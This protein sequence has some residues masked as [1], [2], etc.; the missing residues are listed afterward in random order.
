[1]TRTHAEPAEK[2]N[3]T[4]LDTRF[5]DSIAKQAL[6]LTLP[7]HRGRGRQKNTWKRD[8]EKQRWRQRHKSELVGDKW[9]VASLHATRR[10]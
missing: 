3:G 9:C 8:L 5:D 1:M 6:W 2:E 7:G 10:K 4:S